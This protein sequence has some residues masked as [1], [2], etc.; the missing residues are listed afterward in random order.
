[1]PK[2]MM[3]VVKSLAVFLI[4]TAS[5]SCANNPKIMTCV[6]GESALLCH[7]PKKP[8]NERDFDVPFDKALNWVATD[9]DNYLIG[10][11]WVKSHCK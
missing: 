10:Q 9:P 7:D 6:I 4:C 5:L 2:R 11:E 1:M 3:N 8:E